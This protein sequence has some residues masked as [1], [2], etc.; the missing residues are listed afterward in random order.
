M[1]LPHLLHREEAADL[2]PLLFETTV[3]LDENAAAGPH[4]LDLGEGT[5]LPATGGGSGYRALLEPPVREIAV[6]EVDGEQVGILWRAPYRLDLTGRL[7]AGTSRLRLRIHGTTAAA[8]AAPENAEA[9]AQQVEAAHAVYGERFQMQELD[10]MLDGVA[11]G[12][13][14][15][16][17]LRHS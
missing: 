8:A 10:R 12:L 2:R 5:P 15:V 4:V 16:P 3:T 13:G 9:A 14:T 11:T 1:D 6:V 17:V 7:R